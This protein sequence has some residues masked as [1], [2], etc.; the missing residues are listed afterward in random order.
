MDSAWP[1][2]RSW[3]R[4][5]LGVIS[6]P[7]GTISTMPGRQKM[8]GG[9]CGWADGW[10]RH[11]QPGAQGSLSKTGHSL[12][13]HSYPMPPPGSLGAP[14]T[15]V[16]SLKQGREE[17]LGIWVG[18]ENH[19]LLLEA[20]PGEVREGGGPA[21]RCENPLVACTGDPENG[22]WRGDFPPLESSPEEG[23]PEPLPLPCQVSF[24]QHRL[25]FLPP[26]GPVLPVEHRN[27]PYPGG[28]G[29]PRATCRQRKHSL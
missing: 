9:C 20:Q 5:P 4:W 16:R 25:N 28:G 19:E 1:G 18:G 23:I 6:G 22:S 15:Q 27:G 14:Q 3:A 29:R 17:K 2:V 8:G 10:R 12:K 26:T 13:G 7:S 11:A 21:G 24:L